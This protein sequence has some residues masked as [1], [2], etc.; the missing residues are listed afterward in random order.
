MFLDHFELREAP[1]SISPDPRFVYL[2]DRHRDALAHLLYG[3]G[4]G[5]SGGFVL[6]TGEVGTGKTTICR[7]LLEKMPENTRVALILNPMLSAIELL[8][9]IAKELHIPLRGKQGHQKRLVDALN[10]YLLQAYS[11]GLRVVLIIDEAQNL[12]SDSLEQVRLLTNLETNTQKL[13]QIIL[14]GQPEL[15]EML[16]K[17]E[18]RQLSQRITA[19]FHLTA[20]NYLETQHYLQH[21][22]AVA[23][24]RYFPF[25]EESIQLLFKYSGGIPRLINI[26]ADRALLAAYVKGKHYLNPALLK[27]AATEILPN[28]LPSRKS[29]AFLWAAILILVFLSAIL[30]YLNLPGAE[31]VLDS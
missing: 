26:I 6:L 15:R 11:E 30:I 25:S 18:L 13:L 14:L 16:A 2:S 31:H 20:L 9:A 1:F 23:G 17:R 21:R 3:V 28:E 24:G 19:R 22:F 27:L 5:S 4:E 12:S 7:L 8:E 29:R 10:V